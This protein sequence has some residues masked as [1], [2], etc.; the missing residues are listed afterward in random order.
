MA[1]T[2]RR[3]YRRTP[4][5]PL[6]PVVL[7]LCRLE[8]A[9]LLAGAVAIAALAATSRVTH[10]VGFVAADVVA[11]LLLGLLLTVGAVRTWARTPVLLVQLFAVL[12]ST[13]LWSS[14]R[15]GIA[16]AVGPVAALTALLIVRDVRP[17]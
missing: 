9:G 4:T 8:A 2:N 16:L 15:V 14:G 12:I 6:P 11:A 10:S 7:W 3:R 5:R 1:S 13:Q 17:R